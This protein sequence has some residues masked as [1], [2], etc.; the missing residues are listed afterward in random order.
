MQRTE[1]K[2]SAN[3]S[4]PEKVGGERRRWRQI[5]AQDGR[6]ERREGTKSSVTE[7][8]DFLFSQSLR[9]RFSRTFN[10]LASP[11]SLALLFTFLS[12]FLFSLYL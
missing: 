12:I 1:E 5:D 2:K 11:E 10:L 4:S 8:F 6:R 3:W 7:D 9:L